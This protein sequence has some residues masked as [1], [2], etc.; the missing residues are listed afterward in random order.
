VSNSGIVRV[1]LCAVALTFGCVVFDSQDGDGWLA[2]TIVLYGLPLAAQAFASKAIRIYGTWLGIFL[3]AQAVCKPAYFSSDYLTLPPRLDRIVDSRGLRGITGFQRFTTD[4]KG[5]RITKAV[6]YDDDSTF[7]I[8][9]VGGSTTKQAYLGDL[10]TWTH[11]L[12]ESLPP[13]ANAKIEVINTGLH[14]LM[15]INHL[16]TM[17]ETLKFN[18]DVYLI[19]VG[20]NDWVYY[21]HLE[22]L[23]FSVSL[24][25]YS[26]RKTL[27]G[28][29]I[30]RIEAAIERFIAKR[31]DATESELIDD[32]Q[33]AVGSE[34]SEVV[35]PQL[36]IRGSL[37][38]KEKLTFMP[39]N[40]RKEYAAVLSEIVDLCQRNSVICVFVTQA[41]GYKQGISSEFKQS[42]GMTSTDK[43]KRTTLTFDSMVHLADLYNR[44]LIEFT[45]ERNV[46]L[47]DLDAVLDPSF[48]NY[49]DEMHFNEQGARRVA[50]YLRVCLS[51]ILIGDYPSDEKLEERVTRG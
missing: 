14:G 1:G 16:A 47:C 34:A 21:Q 25:D 35:D 9:A 48:E 29:A 2:M 19:M 42:F 36:L 30:E 38:R 40:V 13:V 22:H 33:R 3:V 27:L 32:M 26:L 7:R 41:T 15:A 4:E 18:P 8:F 11:L 50:E 28:R 6:D 23:T 46:P 45:A 37:Y 20:G 24:E 49:Y 31:T 43:H 5:F 51:D 44:Y 39:R 12:Q 10:N 17:K